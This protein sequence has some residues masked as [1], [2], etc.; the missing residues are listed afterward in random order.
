MF[1]TRGHKTP[2]INSN[3]GRIE[4][5]EKCSILFVFKIITKYFQYENFFFKELYRIN[6]IQDEPTLD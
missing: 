6:S 1:D 5:S 2:G 3:I 4:L